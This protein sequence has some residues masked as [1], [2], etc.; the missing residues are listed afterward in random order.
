MCGRFVLFTTDE[1]LLENVPFAT[2]EMP[3]GMPKARYNIAPTQVI[4]V[5][6]PA[7]GSGGA[8]AGVGAGAGVGGAVATEMVLEPARWGLIPHWAKELKGPPLFNARAETVASKP[9]FREAFKR[10]RCAIPMDGYYEWTGEGEAK[11]PNFI[12][13]GSPIWVAGLYSFGLDQLSATMITTDAQAPLDQVHH[14]MPRFL[15]PEEMEQWIFG[16]PAEAEELL[17]PADTTGFHFTP[18]P[19]EVGSVRNDYPEL[20]G[21]ELGES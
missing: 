12:R 18:A 8:E 17:T 1:R 3:Y 21:L 7:G 15:A 19:K 10:A 2:I 5:L 16:S 20:M 11:H 9:S 13:T 4:P 14:R 6:R